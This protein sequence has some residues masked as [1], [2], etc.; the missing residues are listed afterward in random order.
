MHQLTRS[1]AVEARDKIIACLTDSESVEIILF[2][3]G[4]MLCIYG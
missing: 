3:S 2:N 1:S 4:R